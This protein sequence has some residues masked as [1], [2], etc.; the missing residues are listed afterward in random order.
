ML[1]FF[2]SILFLLISFNYAQAIDC[3]SAITMEE[4]RQ[5]G[6]DLLAE[7]DEELN[8]LYKEVLKKLEDHDR[9][10]NKHSTGYKFES[11]K[12][13]IEAQRNWV[14]FKEMDCD[15]V[16]AYTCCGS[17]TSLSVTSC[18]IDRTEQR[19]EELKFF[20]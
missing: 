8:S 14:K 9:I 7:K 15:A 2:I 17:S 1:K 20:Q 5:C 19:I 10:S 6:I 16:E 18:L 13:L 4:M 11:K 3:N 12:K